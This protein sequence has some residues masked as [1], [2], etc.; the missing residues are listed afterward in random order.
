MSVVTLKMTIDVPSFKAGAQ[1]NTW[2]LLYS[3]LYIGKILK[4]RLQAKQV[5]ITLNL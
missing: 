1:E 3:L 5:I 2:V 4:I